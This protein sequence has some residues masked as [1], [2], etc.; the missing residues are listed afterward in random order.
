MSSGR[1]GVVVPGG[2]PGVPSYRI[3]EG[4]EVP[5]IGARVAVPFG[6]KLLTGI[7]ADLAPEA[8][9]E[10]TVER[11]LVA[12]LDD[13][14]FL[15]PALVGVLLRASTY[16]F[17]APG[18][19]LRAAVP[20]RLLAAAEAVY[21]ATPGAVGAG[22][23]DARQEEILTEVLARGRARVSELAGAIGAR[24]LGP[25][26]RA[27]VADGLLRIPAESARAATAPS[28]KAWVA[29]PAPPDDPA[30]ARAPKR[31]ALHAHL[32]ALG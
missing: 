21:V 3:P 29:R 18:E 28:D 4:G 8:L 12:V 11:E 10:G 23:R 1:V 14:P 16:Y 19:M 13:A 17:V 25:A 27:L 22:R 9:A 6:P 30:F 5:A 2:F 7:A 20:A 26:L 32:A 24:G 15:P 31:R